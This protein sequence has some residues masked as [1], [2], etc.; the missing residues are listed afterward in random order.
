MMDTF[1]IFKESWFIN[2]YAGFQQVPIKPG[3]VNWI[4][5]SPSEDFGKA[6]EW[7]TSSKDGQAFGELY[8]SVYTCQESFMTYITASS[9]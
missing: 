6:I 5:I 8:Q 4:G 3:S 1:S 7:F 2:S 9:K